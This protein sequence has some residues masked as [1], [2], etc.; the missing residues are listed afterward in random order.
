LYGDA[1]EALRGQRQLRAF[2]PDPSALPAYGE[3]YE[4]WCSVLEM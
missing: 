2:A 3:A 4:R 1:A